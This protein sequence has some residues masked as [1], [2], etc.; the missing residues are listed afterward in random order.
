MTNISHCQR[1]DSHFRKLQKKCLTSAR[2]WGEHCMPVGQQSSRKTFVTILPLGYLDP[3]ISSPNQFLVF[4]LPPF[5]L[6][7]ETCSSCFLK[8]FKISGSPKG[9][10]SSNFSSPNGLLVVLGYQA[11]TKFEDWGKLHIS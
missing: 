7:R 4:I 2:S 10:C 9:Y 6:L 5:L 8:F 3:Q 11:T 1:N